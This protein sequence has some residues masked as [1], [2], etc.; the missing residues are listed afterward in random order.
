M[1]KFTN[2][3]D[4]PRGIYAKS[5]LVMVEAGDTFDGELADGETPNDEW[6]ASAR[7]AAAREAAKADD[8]K[9]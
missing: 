9:D 7:S 5:G 6:F 1:P 3:S 4:G 2:I 8:T